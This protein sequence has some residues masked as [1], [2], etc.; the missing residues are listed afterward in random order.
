MDIQGSDIKNELLKNNNNVQRLLRSCVKCKLIPH[1]TTWT[2]MIITE[3]VRLET[4]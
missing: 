2:Q 3:T 4:D 1:R